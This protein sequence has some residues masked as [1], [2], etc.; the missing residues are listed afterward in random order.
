MRKYIIP[1]SILLLGTSLCAKKVTPT[2]S[3]TS[4]ISEQ[5]MPPSYEKATKWRRF[6]CDLASGACWF[7]ATGIQMNMH[8]ENP[9]NVQ[10]PGFQTENLCSDYVI[11][12]I[13]YLG[14]ILCD[15]FMPWVFGLK[16]V[17][18]DYKEATYLQKCMRAI[19]WTPPFVLLFP[20]G[21]K[22]VFCGYCLG[23]LWM[24]IMWLSCLFT[25]DARGFHGLSSN[26][27]IVRVKPHLE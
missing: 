4:A 1:I 24:F 23:S 9:N 14:T 2:P 8:K 27:T 17:N 20:L 7:I 18:A 5:K 6:F 25:K 19:V 10:D 21:E 13:I 16:V 12:L 3:N 22:S 11:Y 15:V 26:T